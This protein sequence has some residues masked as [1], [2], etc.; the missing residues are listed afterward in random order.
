MFG[1]SSDGI[2]EYTISDTGFMNKCIDAVVPTVTVRTYHNQKPWITGNIRIELKA[3]ASAFKEQET[4]PDTYKKSC[5]ALRRTIT[6]E[7]HQYRIKIDARWMWQGLKT[8]MDYKGKPRH[9][10]PSYTEPII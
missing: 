8:I 1:D 6:Q 2:E 10:L 3:R 7:K 9:E 5:Y 4:N